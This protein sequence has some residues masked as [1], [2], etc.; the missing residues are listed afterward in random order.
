MKNTRIHERWAK[1]SEAG[2]ADTKRTIF[3]VPTQQTRDWDKA[4]G[5]Q[6]SPDMSPG[7]QTGDF[8]TTEGPRKK[9]GTKSTTGRR[10]STKPSR[11]F[12]ILK[13]ATGT[14]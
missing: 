14:P 5:Y 8:T 1:L 6:P 11:I 9:T 4:R 10:S 13:K 2:A 12:D 3:R 7:A